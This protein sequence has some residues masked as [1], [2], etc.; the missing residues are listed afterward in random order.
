MLRLF[1]VVQDLMRRIVEKML[2]A[3]EFTSIFSVKL[4]KINY[5]ESIIK[6]LKHSHILCFAAARKKCILIMFIRR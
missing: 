4:A 6:K 1:S 2:W 5:L 3:T